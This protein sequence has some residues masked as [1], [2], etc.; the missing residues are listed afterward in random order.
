MAWVWNIYVYY[1]IPEATSDLPRA[2]PSPAG[3]HRSSFLSVFF[4]RPPTSRC[5]G[6][7]K[8]PP[9]AT[10]FRH[11]RRSGPKSA[12]Q[13]FIP[14]VRLSDLSLVPSPPVRLFDLSPVA[15]CGDGGGVSRCLWR[16][17]RHDP[18]TAQHQ[19]REVG[20]GSSTP[21][22]SS[23]P[24]SCGIGEVASVRSARSPCGS[25][26]YPTQSW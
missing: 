19:I 1:S 12:I 15:R 22:I 2:M 24:A 10:P 18:M 8:P 23:A 7:R 26:T 5:V 16:L 6:P 4:S 14:P 17:H 25:S 9:L 21:W 11:R 3:P 13:F 20:S